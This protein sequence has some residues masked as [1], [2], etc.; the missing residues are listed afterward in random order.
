MEEKYFKEALLNKDL[1]LMKKVPKGD[2]HNHVGLGMRFSTFNEWA[3][4]KVTP[5]PTKMK[6]IQG[7]DDYI[8]NETIQYCDSKEGF[9]FLLKA[10][11][12]EAIGDGVKVL[13]PSIDWSNHLYYEGFDKYFKH[14]S[15]MVDKYKDKID[16]RPEIGVARGTSEK[17][18]ENGVIPCIEGNVFKSIDLY[19]CEE[20]NNLQLYK[21]YFDYAR[22]KNLKIKAHAGE[23][24][25]AQQLIETIEV[26]NPSEIQHGIAALRSSKAL[27]MIKERKIRLN[28]CPSSNVILGAV[29]SIEAH[30]LK[31]LFYSGVSIAIN[32]DD[33]LLFDRSVSE[34]FL[35]VHQAGLLGVDELN[36]IR[37]N[38]LR[39]I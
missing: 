37:K 22:E 32:T 10:T 36:E 17:W 9:E 20:V 6:G 5:P 3:G 23:F 7:L 31:D 25:D 8:F 13:E 38:G 18:W 30:P 19:G 4:G 12:E 35:Y 24:C 39:E 14:I 16:F 11:I 29:G 21:K 26:L 15:E 33:L 27:E 2:C 34:E 28:I 1:K